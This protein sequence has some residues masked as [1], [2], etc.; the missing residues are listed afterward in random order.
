MSLLIVVLL[1]GAL[2][3]NHVSD[4]KSY[5][6]DRNFRLLATWSQFISKTLKAYVKSAEFKQKDTLGIEQN[7]KNYKS[8]KKKF[9]LAGLEDEDI[10]RANFKDYAEKII[11]GKQLNAE[12]IKKIQK[13]Q[14]KFDK[15]IFADLINE[16]ELEPYFTDCSDSKSG[17]Y[18]ELYYSVKFP[19]NEKEQKDSEMGSLEIFCDI[20][21]ERLF[22]EIDA[23]LA[24]QDLLLIDPDGKVIYQKEG[25]QL[26]FDSFD[27]LFNQREAP[28]WL[29]SLFGSMSIQ[30]RNDWEMSDKSKDKNS[31][32]N[33]V[34][35]ESK[36][37]PIP[38]HFKVA[39]GGTSF[40][41]FSQPVNLPTGAIYRSDG[42]RLPSYFL[43]GIVSNGDF[44]KEYLAIPFTEL[45]I[46]VFVLLAIILSLPLI[47]LMLVDARQRVTWF[48]VAS[49][50]LSSVIGTA[51]LTFFLC[52]VF[53][54]NK[55][56]EFLNEQLT[57]T[58]RSVHQALGREL[59][60]ILNVL[61]AYNSTRSIEYDM[62][63][64]KSH[65]T[66]ER[67]KWR[68][69]TN[70]LCPGI[71]K[72]NDG[73]AWVEF[74]HPDC[75]YPHSLVVFWVDPDGLG[76]INWTK[77]PVPNFVG[78]PDLNHR[79]YVSNVIN[80]NAP[81][82]GM[83]AE[84][85]RKF[86]FFIEPIISLSGSKKTVVVSTPY[87]VDDIDKPWVAAIETELQSLMNHPVLPTRTGFAVIENSTGD[88]WFHSKHNRGFKMENFF[89]ETDMNPEL[90]ALVYARTAGF[91]EGDYWG[92]GHQFY[93]QPIDDLP[94]TLVVYQEKTA[95]R[96][97]NFEALFFSGSLYALYFVVMALS[98]FLCWIIPKIV[99]W[100]AG[101]RSREI[102]SLFWL[103][104]SQRH[105][106]IY[107][108]TAGVNV[109][110]L[111][112]VLILWPEKTIG[113]LSVVE[114]GFVWLWL[115]SVIAILF[116]FLLAFLKGNSLAQTKKNGSFTQASGSLP[117]L[118]YSVMG[119]SFLLMLAIFPAILFFSS[120]YEEEVKRWV[121]HNLYKLASD[122]I[123]Y[124][125]QEMVRATIS[126][127]C[128]DHSDSH[129]I[130]SGIY[131]DLLFPTTLCFQKSA[132]VLQS[133]DQNP[134]RGREPSSFLR[135]F[136]DSVRANTLTRGPLY[137]RGPLIETWA[138]TNQAQDPTMEWVYGTPE[139]GFVNPRWIALNV[140]KFPSREQRNDRRVQDSRL[141][142][143]SRLPTQGGL[144]F[145]WSGSLSPWETWW[146]YCSF[147]PYLAIV[148]CLPYFV[149][150]KIIPRPFQGA[151]FRSLNLD[152]S[153]FS[154]LGHRNLLILGPPGSGKTNFVDTLQQKYQW[155][156]CDCRMIQNDEAWAIKELR[157][158]KSSQGPILLDHF[159]YRFDDPNYDRQ[160]QE[161]IENLVFGENPRTLYVLSAINP[162]SDKV[163]LRS[164]PTEIG[165]EGRE[166]GGLNY[167]WGRLFGSFSLLYYRE[168]PQSSSHA[169]AGSCSQPQ[170]SSREELINRE[171]I[172]LEYEVKADRH[173]RGLGKWIQKQKGWESWTSEE[174]VTQLLGLA[175]PHYQNIWQSCTK[176]EK[177]ALYH[178]ALDRML[179]ADNPE[180]PRLN[181]KGLVQFCPS[182]RLMNRSFRRFILIAG[183]RDKLDAWEAK[184][185]RGIWER[186]RLP[187]LLLVGGS[188]VFLFATQQEF[189]ASL[190]AFASIL[191]L[192][193]PAIPE[194]P[195]F[196]MQNRYGGKSD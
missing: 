107:L 56:K 15:V 94:W 117:F 175:R 98:V 190:A 85:G 126:S 112:F 25:S 46:L 53:V 69:R 141:H 116:P 174:V 51:V 159:E 65:G 105:R 133:E 129:Y 179:H 115:A 47:R 73:R 125:Q 72:E 55:T 157:R 192:L 21:L 19:L 66:Q 171:H 86:E 96:G 26:L 32:K 160:R 191:P 113:D 144:M 10:G 173:L 114:E 76:R 162:L 109:L 169:L 163:E 183:K 5:L 145:G 111:I 49:M 45:L 70:V 54:F 108:M 79:R 186:S 138:F 122:L 93:V 140:K 148:C 176:E 119:I 187:L 139:E 137:Q 154:D 16:L 168:V 147:I 146:W 128:N 132:P 8:D 59:Q 39:L 170:T 2:Y 67:D 13:Y 95:I 43:C 77:E 99:V 44:K 40:Q 63:A 87:I 29:D 181:L 11:K 1:G 127:T 143:A 23:R 81:L 196:L 57:K 153:N 71:D 150:R 184:Q 134:S 22:N 195:G 62:A 4:R 104:P 121:M 182:L 130:S 110:I 52:D 120:A 37:W 92:K 167:Q 64:M 172:E 7:R 89:K 102:F 30:E 124:P 17:R 100:L 118:P 193:F 166:P 78:T 61:D 82:F 194:L 106:S 151:D 6:I 60:V 188:I 131:K 83:R 101:S 91:V 58:A 74:G 20:D 123:E 155:A 3:L 75:R 27:S 12:L 136:Y 189:K 142:L 165:K 36:K 178:L 80:S 164:V 90:E 177:L 18:K 68:A 97:F 35:K 31:S 88:V 135:E 42:S 152:S 161:L 185:D 103:W 48:T 149:I 50:V 9:L 158:L 84:S 41:V 34:S 24:F 14:G 38:G 33:N 156:K 28:S 180:L